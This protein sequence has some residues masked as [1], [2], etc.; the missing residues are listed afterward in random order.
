MGVTLGARFVAYDPAGAKRGI[1]PY[2]LAAAAR[3]VFNDIG[4]GSIDYLADAQHSP[5]LEGLCEVAAEVNDGRGWTEVGARM[6]RLKRGGSFIEETR[7]RRY[8]LQSYGIQLSKMRMLR[9]ETLDENSER[10]IV[11]SSVGAVIKTLFDEAKSRGNATAFQYDFTATADS[12]GQPWGTTLPP[13]TLRFGDDLLSLLRMLADNGACD[14]KIQGR[15]LRMFKPDTLGTN[16]ATV[17]QLFNGIDVLEAPDD[18]DAT[19]MAG[20]I[21]VIGDDGRTY[22][23]I[24]PT[25]NPWGLWEE[26]VNASGVKDIGGLQ[27]IGEAEQRRRSAPRVQM[28]R[29]VRTVDVRYLPILDYGTGDT[30]TVPNQSGTPEA[31]RVRELQLDIGAEGVSVN[32]TLNDLILER[33]ISDRRNWQGMLGGASSS[34]GGSGAPATG[35]DKRAPAVPT[36]FVCNSVHLWSPTGEPFSVLDVAFAP[37]VTG[38]DGRPLAVQKHELYG[39]RD[40]VGE[41]WRKITDT[42]SGVARITFSPMPVGELWQFKLRAISVDGVLG[43]FTEP[44]P[45]ELAADTTPPDRPEA[46]EASTRLGQIIVTWKGRTATGDPQPLDFAHADVLMATAPAGVAQVVGQIAPSGTF[47][48][49]EQPYNEPRWFSL[50]AVDSS[51]N[52]SEES[53]RATVSTKP[54]VDT[55]LIGRVIDGINVKTGTLGEDVMAPAVS[56]KINQAADD[57]SNAQTKADDAKAAAEAAQT[58][59]DALKARGTD[60][61]SN[62]NAVLGAE[63]FSQFALEVGDQPPGAAGAF[64]AKTG[65]ANQVRFLDEFVPIDLS[66]PILPSM[67]VRQVNAGVVSRCYFGLAPYDVD[68][69]LIT[70]THYGEASGTRTTLTAPLVAGQASVQLASAAA[71]P[72]TGPA[73]VVMIWGYTDGKGKKWG[74]GTYTRLISAYNAGGV[75][76]N[77]LTLSTPWTGATIPAGT[78]ISIGITGGTYMYAPGITNALVPEQWTQLMATVPYGGVHTDTSVPATTA[79]PIATTQAKVVVLANYGIVSGTPKQLFAGLSLSEANAAQLRA[80][81]AKT[82]ADAAQAAAVAAQAAAGNAQATAN[83]AVTSAAGKSAM[84]HDITGPSGVG[85]RAGDVWHQWSSMGINGRLLGTWRWDGAAWLRTQL[86]ETYIPQLNIGAGTYGSLRGD[87]LVANSVTADQIA[88]KAVTAGKIDALAV[89][90]G[91]IASNAIT[92]DKIDAGAVTAAK[93]AANAIT[94]EKISGDAIDGKT[95]TGALIRSAAIGERTEMTPSG[96]RAVNAAGQDLVRVGYGVPTGMEVRNP[97]SGALVPLANAAFGMTSVAESSSLPFSFS[98]NNMGYQSGFT[99]HS[100]DNCILQFT[101]VSSA[102]IIDF[103]QVWAISFVSNGPTFK[104]SVGIMLNGV[105]LLAAGVRFTATTP[106]NGVSAWNTEGFR[107]VAQARGALRIDTTPGAAYEVRMDFSSFGVGNSSSNAVGS[108]SLRDRFIIATPVFS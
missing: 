103:A 21:G 20:R 34:A 2:P 48:A 87:R 94:G 76:G 59:S 4:G 35:D 9:E 29:K 75:N 7:T 65:A 54:L 85:G 72:N 107:R 67:W 6:L 97:Y 68:G 22:E 100:A 38:A 25:I 42:P 3:D 74:P 88:A 10:I 90:A 102:Y 36:G 45:L 86:D 44:V 77:T 43:D 52:R 82:A 91:E 53:G 63:N 104:P 106:D 73:R 101:A 108:V 28:T 58:M 66:K 47:V 96:F 105:G 8:T 89:S 23:A 13:V 39:R 84:F 1:L 55:D 46:P 49:P 78:S 30:I 81:Q 37:V 57:A 32:A 50:V 17:I 24:S 51:G 12:N 15:T 11:A 31:V 98:Y 95:I 64:Y 14:W 79:F 27:F 56:D 40:V 83:T 62:G 60:L 16:R 99:R 61:I 92:A 19:E 69:L 26:T 18:E 41:V 71:W 93:V 5:L 33:D 80:A 70:P